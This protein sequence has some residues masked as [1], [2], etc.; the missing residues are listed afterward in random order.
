M[1]SLGQ[2]VTL[3]LD[4]THDYSRHFVHRS[5]T[6]AAAVTALLKDVLPG[7]PPDALVRCCAARHAL[8]LCSM[9]LPVTSSTAHGIA[10]KGCRSARCVGAHA[11]CVLLHVGSDPP[12]RPP[13]LFHVR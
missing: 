7:L 4:H 9:V 10:L 12:R 2:Y 8:G 6:D 5:Q 1:Q 11:A 3:V 13:L